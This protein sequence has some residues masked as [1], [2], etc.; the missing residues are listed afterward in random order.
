M[1]D[2]VGREVSIRD[3]GNGWSATDAVTHLV[4]IGKSNKVR[5]VDSGFRGVGRLAGL[6]FANCVTFLTRNSPDSTVTRV[7]WNGLELRQRA[8]SNDSPE[9]AIKQST[10]VDSLSSDNYPGHFFEVRLTDVARHAAAALL[11]REAVGQYIAEIGPVPFGP[12]FPFRERVAAQLSQHPAT[13]RAL[14]VFI[15]GGDRILRPYKEGIV[16]SNGF[17]DPF[18]D[19]ESFSVPSAD[20]HDIAA[21]GWIAHS[22]YVRAI[23]KSLGIR[24]IRAREGNI[25]IGGEAV[26]DHL[27]PEARFNRWCVGEVHVVDSRIVPDATRNYFEPGPHLRNLENHLRTI[28]RSITR[29][30]RSASS[31]R[32]RK[33][34]YFADIQRWEEA[35]EL[36]ACGY[37]AVE[38]AR[39]LVA[40][41]LE[42]M[43]QSQATNSIGIDQDTSVAEIKTDLQARLKAFEIPNNGSKYNGLDPSELR[44]YQTVCRTL[45]ETLSSPRQAIDVIE[46]ALAAR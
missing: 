4:P 33:M 2:P 6:T 31:K 24:G 38:D 16:F 12:S 22:S 23:P 10:S 43:Q 15:H 19:L 46:A 14:D 36:A 3:F 30:C 11:N 20:N 13:N 26:F 29:K 17:C 28:A 1:I 18:V 39:K 7:S 32:H 37:L 41:T 9:Q 34:R 25:Q 44:V 35:F 45:A 21:T 42:E 27:F 5:G 8:R 40:N